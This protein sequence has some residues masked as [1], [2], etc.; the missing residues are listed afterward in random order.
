LDWIDRLLGYIGKKIVSQSPQIDID[1]QRGKNSEAKITLKNAGSFSAY[2]PAVYFTEEHKAN[3]TYVFSIRIL[4]GKNNLSA[5][6]QIIAPGENIQFE[7]N[8]ID[9]RGCN[10]TSLQTVWVEYTD[11]DKANYRTVF[12]IENASGNEA[13]IEPPVRIKYRVPRLLN[14]QFSTNDHKVAKKICKGKYKDSIQNYYK[15][16]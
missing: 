16:K 5:T 4:K 2:N 13:S 8:S 1:I 12:I 14:L 10:V 3:Q 6:T 7:G 9:F 15:E 11:Q